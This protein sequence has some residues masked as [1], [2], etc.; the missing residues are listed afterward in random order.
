MPWAPELFSAPVLERIRNRAAD[1]RAAEPVPYFTGVASG[2]TEALV[3]S[4]SGEPELHHPLRGRVK[5]E[6]EFERF[7]STTNTWLN[8]LNAEGGEVSRIVTPRRA[9]EETVM[10]LDRAGGRIEVPVATVADRDE[11]GR[12]IELRI[13][14]GNWPLTGGHTGRPPLLQPD[15]DLRPPDVV[16]E[17]QRAVAAGDVEATVATFEPDGYVREPAGGKYMHRGREALIALYERV[18]SNGGG[19]QAENCAIA[20]DGRSCAVEYNIVQWGRTEL[21]PAAAVAVYVPGATGKLAA[22]R[23]YDDVDPPI[24]HEP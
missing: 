1:A 13:Y 14:Y 23:I 8:A 17:H 3:R 11:D 20:E 15:P 2:E 12:I 6:R 5:G 9:I 19:I 21:P 7:I 24:P 10:K 4:F 18:F 22:V 16:S